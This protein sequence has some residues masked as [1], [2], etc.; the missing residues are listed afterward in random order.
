[1]SRPAPERGHPRA[2]RH[3]LPEEPARALRGKVLGGIWAGAGKKTALLKEHLQIHL[4][5]TGKGRT[6]WGPAGGAVSESASKRAPPSG[7]PVE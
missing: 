6:N 2:A 5:K 3:Q 1:M 7:R 4:V